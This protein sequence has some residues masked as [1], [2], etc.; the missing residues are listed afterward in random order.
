MNFH[1][2][3]STTKPDCR[4]VHGFDQISSFPEA[5]R[6]I[7]DWIRRKK[8]SPANFKND[9]PSLMETALLI[10]AIHKHIEAL[11]PS[12]DKEN[13]ACDKKEETHVEKVQIFSQKLS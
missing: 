3:G 5:A 10:R 7:E 4:F 12:A 8:H 1:E 9:L 13:A 6:F 11:S 2:P